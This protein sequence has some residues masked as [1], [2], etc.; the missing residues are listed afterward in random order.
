MSKKR[1]QNIFVLRKKFKNEDGGPSAAAVRKPQ[2][3][4]SSSSGMVK[5]NIFPI[6]ANLDN[7]K[8]FSGPLNFLCC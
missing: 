7:L 4:G 8:C 6:Q 2:D 1:G 5:K 3:Q